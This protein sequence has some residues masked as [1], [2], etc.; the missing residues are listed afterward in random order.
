[1]TYSQYAY[2]SVSGYEAEILDL[3]IAYICIK[4]TLAALLNI[5]LLDNCKTAV[6]TMYVEN[7]IADLMKLQL[8]G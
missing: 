5:L 2:V 8:N 3:P 7:S 1:M 6:V 4:N